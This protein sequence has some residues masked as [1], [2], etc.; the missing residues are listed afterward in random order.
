[1]NKTTSLV[2]KIR[3][4]AGVLFIFAVVLIVPLFSV[5]QIG[6]FL[7]NTFHL[8]DPRSSKPL[9]AMT[10]RPADR[11]SQP[12]KLFQEPL[13]SVTFDDGYETTYTKAMPLLQKYG[14]HTT[15][16]VLSGTENDQ[17]YVSW[18]QVK[19]M[20]EAGHEI[21]CHTVNHPDLTTLDDEDLNYQLKTCKEI[22]GA[23]A[24]PVANFASPYGAENQHTLGV[25]G[26]Y[27]TSQRNTNGDPTNGVTDADVNVA[28]NFN[29]M[30][31][32][33]VTVRNDTT[34]EQLRQLVDYAKAHN[35]WVVLTY[36]Q[37][38]DANSKYSVSD[39]DFERQFAY[40]SGTDVR[41][42]TVQ[43]AL[44]SLGTNKAGN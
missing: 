37:A 9:A 17:L 33:G 1:M 34:V 13:V 27:F 29:R 23:H 31:I 8:W 10:V 19:R 39:Q 3:H 25:I 35:G 38:D 20:Q 22:M 21:A 15:Q 2:S 5:W 43:Q 18:A 40:L 30:D 26:K 16:Y 36:H 24:G 6:R 4:A 7:E 11:S 14:I 41:I 44:A 28:A 32:I 12:P 42:V